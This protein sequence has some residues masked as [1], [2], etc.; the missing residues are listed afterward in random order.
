MSP[1]WSAPKKEERVRQGFHVPN[2]IRDRV[3][4][5]AVGEIHAL[6]KMYRDIR[7]RATLHLVES[8]TVQSF[9][10]ITEPK[11]LPTP[12]QHPRLK[13][14]GRLHCLFSSW[15]DFMKERRISTPSIGI[16]L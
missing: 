16:P 14:A 4:D 9:E 5:L 10:F 6:S 7:K 12:A 13:T 11:K 15:K 8:A 1:W 3:S 2:L